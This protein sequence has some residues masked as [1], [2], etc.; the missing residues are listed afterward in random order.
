VLNLLL[1]LKDE[2]GLAYL[3]VSHNLDVVR[4]LADDVLVLYLGRVV[5]QGPRAAIFARP[6]HPYTQ[7][8]LAA[9]PSLARRRQRDAAGTASP[10][11]DNRTGDRGARGEPPSPLAPPR[12]CAFHARCARATARCADER[13]APR[14]VDGVVVACHFADN[15]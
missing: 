3:F 13:P 15:G 6:R 1:D 11:S 2:L 10:G 9:T 14:R 5:E 12:G 8:L 4:H 7:A